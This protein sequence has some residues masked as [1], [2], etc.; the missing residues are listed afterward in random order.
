[1]QAELN[2][3]VPIVADARR[4]ILLVNLGSPDSTEIEGVKRYLDQFLMDARVLDYPAWIRSLLVRGIILKTRP[5]KSAAA[6]RSVWWAEG[7]PLVVL[8]QRFQAALQ[9]RTDMPVA[10][11]MRYQNPSLEA[12]FKYLL[13]QFPDVQEV[14]LVPLYP[15]YAMST[16]ETV[17]VEARAALQRLGSTLALRV[18]PPFYNHPAYIEALAT[19]T[20]E[21]L[22]EHVDHV[23]FSYHGIPERH[24]QR[25]DTSG[26][27][28]LMDDCCQ[29]PSTAHTYCY[30]HQCLETTRLLANALGLHP[31]QYSYAFQSR[32]SGT[33][34]WLRPFTDQVL[35]QLPE[36][37]KRNLAVICPAF[38]TDCLETLEEIAVEG[39][40]Q[41]EHAG[42]RHFSYI[43]CL[44]DHPA[45]VIALKRL[46][47]EAWHS[48]FREI[49]SLARASWH[50]V[51]T[52]TQHVETQAANRR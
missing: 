43:P 45:W 15:Q 52:A 8:S 42:G 38:V 34:R 26:S 24:I 47:D 29:R 21:H 32:V 5:R 18:L 41:F 6:Y 49:N 11:A 22:P 44:N 3:S 40:E 13:K 14:L 48:D 37:G 46:C 10:L 28:C 12:G 51:E 25:S 35:E 31:D 23:L 50:R 33:G 2:I 27:H 1:V 4:A 39:R 7:S 20:R 16:T 9:A 36:Q 30:R 17:I 19:V